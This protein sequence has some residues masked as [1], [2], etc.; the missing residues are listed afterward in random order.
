[1]VKS[2]TYKAIFLYSYMCNNL[3][4]ELFYYHTRTGV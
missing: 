3:K 1:M 4:I 2:K